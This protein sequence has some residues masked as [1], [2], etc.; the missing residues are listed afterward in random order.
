MEGLYTQGASGQDGKDISE[1]RS[2]HSRMSAD[3]CEFLW[4]QTKHPDPYHLFLQRVQNIW[5][6][7]INSSLNSLWSGFMWTLTFD[8]TGDV[9]GPVWV[10]KYEKV[11]K[12]DNFGF[13]NIW[14]LRFSFANLVPRKHPQIDGFMNHFMIKFGRQKFG[15]RFWVYFPP[16]RLSRLLTSNRDEINNFAKT[17]WLPSIPLIWWKVPPCPVLCEI[18]PIILR[19]TSKAKWNL[20]TK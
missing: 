18:I 19:G 9:F 17:H 3:T 6:L 14:K 5:S 7:V 15:K 16:G 20:E 2:G 1:R 4:G 11:A 13:R 12:V 10:S 8:G